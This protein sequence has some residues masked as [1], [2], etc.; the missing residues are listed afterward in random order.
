MQTLRSAGRLRGEAYWGR[1]Q[2]R[3]QC[4]GAGP[5]RGGARAAWPG[6][7]EQQ[8]HLVAGLLQAQVGLDCRPT[9]IEE[10]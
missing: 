8:R 7:A 5:A 1:G 4:L 6:L 9:S 2:G 10:R 3:G